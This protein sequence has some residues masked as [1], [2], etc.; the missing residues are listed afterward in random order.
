MPGA[1]D[2]RGFFKKRFWI[3]LHVLNKKRIMS[4]SCNS[5]R[6]FA[7][8]FLSLIPIWVRFR[9]M[10]TWNLVT[11][12]LAGPPVLSFESYEH[13]MKVA[14]FQWMLW[15]WMASDFRIKKTIEALSMVPKK[16]S[17]IQNGRNLLQRLNRPLFIYSW[18]PWI[19]FNFETVTVC[20]W[21]PNSTN[22]SWFCYLKKIKCAGLSKRCKK[23]GPFYWILLNKDSKCQKSKFSSGRKDSK[24]CAWHEAAPS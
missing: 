14:V 9:K 3:I 17:W 13:E 4:L 22:V 11:W 24:S 16:T 5:I 19:Y 7:C 10:A 8:C 15:M 21:W 18:F 12:V 2:V 23:P 1:A 20:Y 6:P